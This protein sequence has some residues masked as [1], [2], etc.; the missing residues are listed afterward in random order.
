[1]LLFPETLEQ[2]KLNTDKEYPCT[3]CG[4]A[5]IRSLC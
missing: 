1:M 5:Y 2:F 3:V 4:T